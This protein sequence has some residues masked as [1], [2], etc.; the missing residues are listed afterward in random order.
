MAI[1]VFRRPSWAPSSISPKI[2]VLECQRLPKG[3]N[4]RVIV[5]GGGGVGGDSTLF[6]LGQKTE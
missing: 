4:A 6:D 2:N 3:Y 5:C 1:V